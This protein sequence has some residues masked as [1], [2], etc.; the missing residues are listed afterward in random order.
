MKPKIKILALGGTISMT[1]SGN[2]G[3]SPTLSADDL[4]KSLPQLN[5]IAI[6]T[7]ETLMMKASASLN[8]DDIRICHQAILKAIAEGADGV[9]ILQGT[10]TLEEVAFIFDLL[11]DIPQ[12]I[13]V[14]GAMRA[15]NT[16][17]FDGPANLLAAVSLAGHPA[18]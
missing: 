14:S 1:S 6:I 12:P 9:V 8:W 15:T 10:D 5:D 18:V 2:E 7:T 16:P 17:G 13:V 4:T 3:A 11:F